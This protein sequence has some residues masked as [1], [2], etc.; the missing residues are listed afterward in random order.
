[1]HRTSPRLVRPQAVDWRIARERVAALLP[2]LDRRVWPAHAMEGLTFPRSPSGFVGSPSFLAELHGLA[3]ELKEVNPEL[4]YGVWA[5]LV[6]NVALV[7][8]EPA[9]YFVQC[10]IQFWETM[11][12]W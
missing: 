11:E 5:W 7:G 12:R 6:V 9:L 4:I 8:N 10:A 3:L 1:M 2:S